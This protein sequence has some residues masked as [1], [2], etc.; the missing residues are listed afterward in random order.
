[1][2]SLRSDGAFRREYLARVVEAML[3]GDIA[4]GQD[5][6]R[7]YVLSTLGFE[8]LEH[9]LQLPIGALENSLTAQGR[10]LADNIFRA[11]SYLESLEGSS[12]EV[13]QKA[14]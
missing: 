6:L 5:M 3:E 13:L 10:P 4:V 12:F 8:Q 1:M 9:N 2:E 14:A 11:I 7:S